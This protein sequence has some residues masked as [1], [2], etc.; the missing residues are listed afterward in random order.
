VPEDTTPSPHRAGT[1]AVRLLLAALL[2]VALTGV[3]TWPQ[4]RQL[5]T[6]AASHDDVYFSMWRLGWVGHALTTAPLRLFDANI[7][8]PAPRTLAYSD[9][10]LLEG[11]LALPFSASGLRPVTVYNIV[12]LAG[13]ALSGFAMFVMVRHF[14]GDGLAATLAGFIFA[15]WPYR[16]EHY[17]HL[18]LQWLAWMPLT[19][20]WTHLAIERGSLRWG[21][22]AGVALAL[23]FLSCVYYGVFLGL[24]LPTFA[25]IALVVHK[26]RGRSLAALAVAASV[27]IAA[28]WLYSVPYR[29]VSSVVGDRDRSQIVEYSATW[30]SYLASP[31]ENRL[32]GW[33]ADRFGRPEAR[34]FP[35]FVALALGLLAFVPQRNG[36]RVVPWPLVLAFA[37]LT[38]AAVACSLGLNGAAYSFLYERSPLLHGL[39]APARFAAV[40][41]CGLAALA[42]FGAAGLLARVRSPRGRV[43]LAAALLVAAAGEYSSHPRTV[44]P[45]EADAPPVYR[46][47]RD[48]P[49]APVLELP[50]PQPSGLPGYDPLFEYWSLAHW[51]PLV[52]GYSGYYPPSYLRLLERMR[53]FPDDR[54]LRD[55]QSLGVR[56]LIVHRH[57]YDQAAEYWR[58]MAGL[59]ARPDVRLA[60]TFGEGE[61]EATLFEMREP[62]G[63]LQ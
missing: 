15:F 24:L 59:V 11:V 18:E 42:G 34:S 40:A 44:M 3:M 60:G 13:F 25:V 1:G 27:A 2:F 43:A 33:T 21:L 54:S 5:S 22:V 32:Y 31:C 19:L 38:G 26:R 62:A 29:Q 48:L 20:L 30:S 46:V 37:I 7:F 4:V 63:A 39:R 8:T 56:Y 17:V 61:I 36:R 23:Q 52:N 55:V 51:R 6:H 28:A 10:M 14:T 53:R 35:G 58:V 9:A 45:L 41:G 47:L 16:F 50:L 57:L 12:L 49:A